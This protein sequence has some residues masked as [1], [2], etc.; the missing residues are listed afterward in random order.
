[1]RSAPPPSN[2]RRPKAPL[3]TSALAMVLTLLLAPAAGTTAAG[4]TE[5]SE[6]GPTSPDGTG[7][8]DQAPAAAQA[9]ADAATDVPAVADPGEVP[10][11]TPRLMVKFT[12]PSDE[13]GSKEALV[14]EAAASAGVAD[15]AGLAEAETPTT[16]NTLDD[17]TDVLAFDEALTAE[18][19]ADVIHELEADPRVEYAEPDRLAVASATPATNDPLLNQQFGLLGRNVPAAWSTSTGAGQTVA[20]IDTGLASHP[21]LRGK[22]VPGRDMVSNWPDTFAIDGD[23]RDADPSDPGDRPGVSGCS[24][25]WHGT[26]VAGIA[27]AG[28]NNGIG[29]AGVARDAKIMPVRVLGFC[30]YG[31][32]SDIAAGIRWAAGA[33]IDGTTAAAPA[34]VIN[35]SLNLEGR[36][37]ATMQGAIDYATNRSIPVVVSAGNANKDAANYPPANC[38]NVIAVG[39]ADQNGARTVYSNWGPAVDVLA[40]GG[41]STVPVISTMNSGSTTYATANYGHKY[42]TSMA[43]PFVAGTVALM[44]QADPSLTPA[45]IE[46]TLKSTSTGQLGSR[47]VAPARAVASVAPE[48]PFRDVSLSNQFATEISWVKDRGYLKGWP[49]GTFRPLTKIDR[50][51]MAAVAYRMKGS[52]AFTPPKTSPYKD[53]PTTHQF[54]K[55]ITWARSNGILT[56]WPDGTFRPQ[57]DITRDATAAIFYL[58]AGSPAYT[59]PSTSRFTDLHPGQQF[60]K[61]VHW[62]ASRGITTGWPD[63]TFRPLNTTNRDAMA[64]FIYRYYN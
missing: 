32:E 31:Y 26:H 57:N 20:V 11:E 43:A 19:Q 51:A 42:G 58:M 25:T 21:D 62:L 48:P 3:A 45:Q 28:T 4:A 64:A 49:D 41:T 36:C 1:M 8:E 60:Y 39:A 27:A 6:P 13:Q 55:E 34:T 53:V 14:A 22:T 59:A 2:R 52:P 12:E 5:Q 10:E 38:T 16:V 47:Q 54:Y 56:G 63:G 33:T 24:A 9:A 15:E 37:S 17:G 40:P 44:K 50:D 23:G 7:T 46:S 29:M 18:E 35:M 61:E 30:T